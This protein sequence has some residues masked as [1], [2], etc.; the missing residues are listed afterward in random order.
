MPS[1]SQ[2][3]KVISWLQVVYEGCSQAWPRFFVSF[4]WSC[5]G[6][7]SLKGGLGMM[8]E[9]VTPSYIFHTRAFM[10]YL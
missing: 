10:T 1:V 6:C 9:G 5:C 8:F 4:C 2:G 7:S 3:L